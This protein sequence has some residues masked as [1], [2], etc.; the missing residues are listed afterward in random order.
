MTPAEAAKILVEF[1]RWRRGDPPYDWSADPAKRKELPYTPR[2]IGEAIDIAV[3][4][5]KGENE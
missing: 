2:Q 4:A 3:Q 5:M 1:N